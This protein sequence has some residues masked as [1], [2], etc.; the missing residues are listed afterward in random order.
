MLQAIGLMMA[1]Y[2]FARLLEVA[3]KPDS[4]FREAGFGTLVRIFSIL[5]MI[6]A[7]LTALFLMFGGSKSPL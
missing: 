3:C 4:A 7:V 5:G 2:I 6:A 1:G